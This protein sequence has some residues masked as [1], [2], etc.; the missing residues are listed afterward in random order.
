MENLKLT[1]IDAPEIAGIINKSLATIHRYRKNGTLPKPKYKLNTVYLWNRLEV[2]QWMN[3]KGFLTAY[4]DE[5]YSNSP[6][7]NKEGVK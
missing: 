6:L 2:I 7:Q 4:N 3:E 5:Y 1:C